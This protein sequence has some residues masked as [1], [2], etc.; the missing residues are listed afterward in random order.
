LF[1]LLA[2]TAQQRLAPMLRRV[3]IVD[4]QP[5]RTRALG[6]LVREV[7]LPEI[8]AAPSASKALKLADK[9]DPQLV[10]CAMADAGVDGAAFTR[11]LRRSDLAC[12]K[13]PVILVTDEANAQAI[14]AGRDAGAHEFLKAP[15][16]TK[17]VLRRLEAVFLHPRGWVEAVD[18]VGPDRRRF[19][20]AAYDGPLKRLADAAAPPHSVRVGEALKIVGSALEAAEREPAQALRALLAQTAEIEAAAALAS[21][22][23]LALANAELHGY[24]DEA[25]RTGAALDPVETCRRAIAL[26]RY[27]EREARAAA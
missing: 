15:F 6:E 3:L 7:C 21:D 11:A 27:A 19:N 25:A 2:K 8:W 14:L 12:R 9:V 26:L 4:P 23:R 24:L 10:F 22:Q 1:N 5:A 18:Y 13:A 16:T 17:D 20:S